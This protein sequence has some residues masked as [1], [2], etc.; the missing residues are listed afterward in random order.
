MQDIDI[1]GHA[2]GDVALFYLEPSDVEE[3]IECRDDGDNAITKAITSHSD[4]LPSVY[5]GTCVLCR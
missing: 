2:V 1:A 4:L 3:T 5:E